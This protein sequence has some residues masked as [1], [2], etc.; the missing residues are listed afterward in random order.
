M[1]FVQHL[2][3]KI[4][5]A[6]QKLVARA[7]PIAR[8]AQHVLAPIG[9][10]PLV[11]RMQIHRQRQDQELPRADVRRELMHVEPALLFR[12]FRQVPEQDA[13]RAL[14]AASELAI[15]GVQHA[16]GRGAAGV[17][18]TR[19]QEQREQR[20]QAAAVGQRIA[21]SAARKQLI[22]PALRVGEVA[23]DEANG[24]RERHANLAG[25]ERHQARHA[26]QLPRR[27]AC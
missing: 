25:N 17:A 11:R 21:L 1:L 12:G 24:C 16:L 7:L 20:S 23:F 18:V 9:A 15:A 14:R 26:R 2:G 3:Q 27:M 22:E 13:Q 5:L 4:A 8:P 6:R 10:R 19:A